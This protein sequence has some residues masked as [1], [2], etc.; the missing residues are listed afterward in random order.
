MVSPSPEAIEEAV[1]INF[2]PLDDRALLQRCSSPSEV[3]TDAGIIIPKSAQ[4]PSIEHV[5]HA[6]GGNVREVRVGDRVLIANVGEGWKVKV[7]GIPLLVVRE[8]AILA[9]CSDDEM[10]GGCLCNEIALA[11][12]PCLVCEAKEVQASS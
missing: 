5:V 6:V 4:E 9:V 3:V 12:R 2:R 7:E 1:E 8:E 10:E 11:D